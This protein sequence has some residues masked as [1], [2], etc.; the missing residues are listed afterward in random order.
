MILEIKTNI[1]KCY[2]CI[3]VWT[4]DTVDLKV[5]EYTDYTGGKYE[6][7]FIICPK[8]GNKLEVFMNRDGVWR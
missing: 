2:N 7:H 6:S 1:T 3:T 4:F 8:C 5:R